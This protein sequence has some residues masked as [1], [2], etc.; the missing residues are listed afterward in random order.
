MHRVG[1]TG[2]GTRKGQ[3]ISFC[4]EEEKEVLQQIELFLDAPV[5]VWQLTQTEYAETLEFTQDTSYNWRKLLE[6]A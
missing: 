2:R 6:E 3:A 5:A 1:R 4:S